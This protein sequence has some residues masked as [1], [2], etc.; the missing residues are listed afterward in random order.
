MGLR[1]GWNP[2][3][4]WL[5]LDS[6][7]P[8]YTGRFDLLL[9]HDT[10][11]I[12]DRAT[13]I[14]ATHS[15]QDYRTGVKINFGPEGSKREVYY[16]QTDADRRLTGADYWIYIDDMNAR[17]EVGIMRRLNRENVYP[18][19]KLE[20]EIPLRPGL[21]PDMFVQV[22][23]VPDIGLVQGSIYQVCKVDH[24]VSA[25]TTGVEARLVWAPFDGVI[26]PAAMDASVGDGGIG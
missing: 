5:F 12:E 25:R 9:D 16:L 8:I 7:R 24:D 18:Q 10:P 22:N 20:F 21:R 19:S 23:V 13:H 11:T 6:G 2:F 4:P 15:V 26:T 1:W 3:G 14:K 17:N